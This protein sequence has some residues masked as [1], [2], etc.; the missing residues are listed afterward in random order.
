MSNNNNNSNNNRGVPPPFRFN[1]QPEANHPIWN[2][3]GY[4]AAN[5]NGLPMNELAQRPPTPT[6]ATPPRVN[7][8]RNAP[9]APGR[10]R[11]YSHNFGVAAA[12]ANVNMDP[13]MSF[14]QAMEVATAAAAPAPNNE[15][16]S[17]NE[18]I[19][20]NEENERNEENEENG[21]PVNP[22]PSRKRGR[23][24]NNANGRSV[25]RRGANNPKPPAR[26]GKRKSKTYRK[27]ITKR[28]SVKRITHRAPRK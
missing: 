27:R 17:N 24:G 21:N 15:N 11:L 5:N 6:F 2:G 9:G 26:G 14:S 4:L 1:T 22:P 7:R 12:P 8:G 10:R 25:R 28:R 16:N 18:S 3:L 13:A 23:N 19:Y 20:E